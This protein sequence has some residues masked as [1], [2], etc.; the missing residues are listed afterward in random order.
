MKTLLEM[1]KDNLSVTPNIN[2]ADLNKIADELFVDN[3]NVRL[4][5]IKELK[6]AFESYKLKPIKRMAQFKDVDGYLVAF[7]SEF[8]DNDTFSIMSKSGEDVNSIRIECYGTGFYVRTGYSPWHIARLEYRP[9]K[10]T[11]YE[12]PEQLVE[13]IG[14]IF[15]TGQ[16][17]H[18]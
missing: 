10:D 1:L 5:A 6:D 16:N 9:S 18:K 17:F 11:V 12:V 4:N 13:L 7:I 2:E 15:N 14:K 3:E 8:E